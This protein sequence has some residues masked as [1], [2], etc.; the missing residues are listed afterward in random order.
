MDITIAKAPRQVA[1]TAVHS[2]PLRPL[3]CR[4]I[5]ETALT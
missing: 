5:G 2:T 3:A 4:R 1:N